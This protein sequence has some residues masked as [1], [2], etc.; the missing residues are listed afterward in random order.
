[1]HREILVGGGKGRGCEGGSRVQMIL[2]AMLQ[3][4]H[5]TQYH[6]YSTAVSRENAF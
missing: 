5:C 4:Q 2:C 6:L 1:M 3:R